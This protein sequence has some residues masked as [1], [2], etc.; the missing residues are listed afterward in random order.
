LQSLAGQDLPKERWEFLLIDN[1]SRQSLETKVDL[2]WHPNARHIR[3]DELGLTAARLR[4]IRESRGQTLIYVDD[5]GVLKSDYLSSTLALFETHPWLGV[6]GAG[7]LRPEFEEVPSAKF[8][9]VLH[10]LAVRSVP[11]VVWSNHPEDHAGI[12]YGAGLGVRRIVALGYIELLEKLNA[13]EC[14][15][16]RGSELTCG[17]DNLF[18]FA[19]TF[20]GLGFGVFPELQ[21]THLIPASRLRESYFL[22]LLEAHGF[23]HTIIGHL[24]NTSSRQQPT[25]LGNLRRV[26]SGA[27][28]GWFA[29]RLELAA[30]SG[31]RR[32]RRYISQRALKPIFDK[33]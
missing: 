4:A 7:N 15:D 32:A 20:S 1:A 21:I 24:L 14:L 31:R 18:S 3:E 23:S 2:S 28:S 11:R 27:R 29:M 22:R 25:R 9:S 10:F 6:I 26:V 19:A 12:P 5:D 8:Q 13:S 17:G 33:G 30:Q 16:R